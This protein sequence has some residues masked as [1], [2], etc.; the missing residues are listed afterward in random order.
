MA[1]FLPVRV[2]TRIDAWRSQ[3]LNAPN[4]KTQ[5]TQQF[6]RTR[7]LKYNSRGFAREMQR[8]G[9][10]DIQENPY[11]HP[12][13]QREGG[14]WANG[15]IPFKGGYSLGSGNISGRRERSMTASKQS[16]PCT[17]EFCQLLIPEWRHRVFQ[18]IWKTAV[19]KCIWYW[20]RFVRE[21]YCSFPKSRNLT[22][23]V[24]Y[25]VQC[26]RSGVCWND[27]IGG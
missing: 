9:E 10:G 6:I 13:N 17:Q 3:D 19:T 8:H 15:L 4:W 24:N 26:I 18:V 11:M 23:I 14:F 12:K 1:L 21:A 25:L 20:L 2:R 5:I 16:L 27:V 22:T 7:V